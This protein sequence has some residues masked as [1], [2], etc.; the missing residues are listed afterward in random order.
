MLRRMMSMCYVLFLASLSCGA[1]PDGFPSGEVAQ[2]GIAIT[3]QSQAVPT[4]KDARGRIPLFGQDPA[5]YAGKEAVRIADN[6]LAYQRNNGG[7][8]E[9]WPGI[10]YTLVLSEKQKVGIRA[11]NKRTDSSLD[12]GST[13]TQLRY[14]AKVATATGED[15]FKAA[16]IK[17]VDYPAWQKK[18]APDRNVLLEATAR[19]ALEEAIPRAAKDTTRPMYHYRPPARWMNDICG[20]IYY[21]GYFS[22][23]QLPIKK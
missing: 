14:L 5:W 22:F 2:V 7:F 8:P 23:L 19:A 9:R 12:N 17:G 1:S 6:M 10:D 18:W 21:N 13:H 15:R 4:E 20:A 11:E 3:A 16:F